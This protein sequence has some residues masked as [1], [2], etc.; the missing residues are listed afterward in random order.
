VPWPGRF[1]GLV[2]QDRQL[3]TV[4]CAELN[5]KGHLSVGNGTDSNTE[6]PTAVTIAWQRVPMW[7][8]A[9]LV[10]VLVS[11]IG[12]YTWLI[13][14]AL[15]PAPWSVLMMSVFL[16][17]Y[18]RYFS[19]SGWPKSTQED[20]KQR[21]RS[22]HNSVEVLKWGLIG[23]LLI[24]AFWHS[25]LVVT[26]RVL[27]FPADAFA[28]AYSITGM[29]LSS[30]WLMIIAASLVAGICEETGYRGYM[31]VPLE[32]RYGPIV[33]IPFVSALFLLIHLQQAWAPPLLF[34]LF[35]LSVLLGILAYASGSLIPGMVAHIGLDVLNFSYW[36][37]G[38]AGR[39]NYRPV[40]ETGVDRHILVW[41]LL[42]GTLTVL[43]YRVM[44]RIQAARES[45]RCPGFGE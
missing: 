31:Q 42:L 11:S 35:S 43:L 45:Q 6:I 38:I 18:A 15:V 32:S 33:A 40:A 7:M 5:S 26:F 22:L 10:G 13:V 39:F 25:A 37:T 8:R 14:A 27:E 41:G 21:F 20:R 28:A 9:S 17:I 2:R 1:P 3:A 29:P 44:G 4:S 30:A 23:G 36:W 12:V 16:L 34:H 24:V 19:G